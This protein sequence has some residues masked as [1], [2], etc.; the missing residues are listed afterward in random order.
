MNQVFFG[1]ILAHAKH[2]LKHIT[3]LLT[4]ASQNFLPEKSI[5]DAIR[6]LEQTKQYLLDAK[7]SYE[8]QYVHS[9]LKRL[10]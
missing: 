9:E 4:R 10:K 3:P 8:K 7:Q 5:E 6:H 1:T 2:E